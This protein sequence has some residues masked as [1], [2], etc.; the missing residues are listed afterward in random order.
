MAKPFNVQRALAV[1]LLQIFPPS[2]GTGVVEDADFRERYDL[3]LDATITFNRLNISI[4]RSKLYPAI[5]ILFSKEQSSVAVETADGTSA[6]LSI[7]YEERSRLFLSMGDER[8]EI[9]S[10]WMLSPE[11]DIRLSGFQ[12]EIA[13]RNLP[14]DVI[15]TWRQKLGERL[16]NDHEIDDLREDLALI[17]QEVT[18]DIEDEFSKK[19]S[20]IA[21]L[22]P[23]KA[24]YYRGLI[25]DRG[26]AVNIQQYAEGNAKIQID[27]LLDWDFG[28]GLAQCLLLCANPRLSALVDISGKA[29]E[30]IERFFTWLAKEGD[31]FSQIAGVEI[32]TR[33]L[34]QYPQIEPLLVKIVE[35]IR[36]EDPSDKVGRLA[37]T[38]NL[39][40]FVDGELARTR[41]L[42]DTPPYWRRLA[43]T[44][45]ASTIERVILS[46]G[47]A[48]E[49]SSEWAQLRAQHFFMQSLTDLRE[50]PRWLP[51]L[52]NST[53]LRLELLMRAR[54]AGTDFKANIPEG[55]LRS[56]LLGQ[57][58]NELEALTSVP[59]AYAPSPV[60]GGMTAPIDFP[61][62]LLASLRAPQNGRVLE[63]TIFASVVNFSMTFRFNTEIAGLISNLLRGV[64]Y[65]LAFE[66]GTDITFTLLMGLASIAASARH[67]ELAD[68]V[69]ILTRV[70]GRRGELSADAEAKMRIALLACASRE[71]KVAWCKAVGEWLL[72]IANGQL[73]R[74]EAARFRSN[75]H[76]MCHAAPEL[77]PYTAKVD[78][79]LAAIS[80]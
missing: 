5:R 45:Q 38:T 55:P 71:D 3:S 15:E 61:E 57:G 49:D 7:E 31:L 12:S 27:R 13:E 76:A 58:A 44:A 18:R 6:T 9:P 23:S 54:I 11:K 29:P 26:D 56:L 64:K 74:E 4:D 73:E 41:T 36:D 77:W 79:A 2:I 40:V 30:E 22:V 80:D 62:D 28:R 34:A 35:A 16:L 65:R 53:Q 39:F 46:Y 47:G 17:P 75:L 24:K 51:D 43:A 68:E 42:S 66:Q 33:V 52:M 78:A 50:E 59:T 63:A 60:E 69:R 8:H 48:G 20:R 25:G 19:E 32:G 72:E 1:G 14:K 70:L 10:F 21:V 67:P 37:L